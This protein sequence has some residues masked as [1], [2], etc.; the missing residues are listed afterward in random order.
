[1]P[2]VSFQIKKERKEEKK[3][4]IQIVNSEK[5]TALSYFI[6]HVRNGFQQRYGYGYLQ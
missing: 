4:E 1:M 6:S 2:E 3:E 5:T